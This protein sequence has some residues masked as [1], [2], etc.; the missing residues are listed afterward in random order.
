M[1]IRDLHDRNKAS[2]NTKEPS[3]TVFSNALFQ[4]SAILS[5]AFS[6]KAASGLFSR[7]S[8]EKENSITATGPSSI[9]LNQLL[10]LDSEFF[11][12]VYSLS[13]RKIE[14]IFRKSL[15]NTNKYKIHKTRVKTGYNTSL[16]PVIIHRI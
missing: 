5:D 13:L 1:L 10:A 11:I 8:C 4:R 9:I 15:Y 7:Q 16:L 2:L 6:Q 3:C 12:D 14:I